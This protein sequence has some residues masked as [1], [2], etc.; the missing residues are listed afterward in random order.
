MSQLLDFSVAS[1]A[2]PEIKVIVHLTYCFI[3]F[4][5]TC[6]VRYINEKI[7]DLLKG[8]KQVTPSQDFSCT[9]M[10]VSLIDRCR[11]LIDKMESI[12]I[13]TPIM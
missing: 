12:K 6:S 3:C 9:I 8:K 7:A 13:P 11:I 2:N 1:V 5:S 10:S 4:H